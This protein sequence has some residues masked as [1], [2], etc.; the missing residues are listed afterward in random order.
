[1]LL[2]NRVGLF[3]SCRTFWWVVFL[4]KKTRFVEFNKIVFYRRIIS[5]SCGRLC[6]Y[7]YNSPC[8]R[9]FRFILNPMNITAHKAA[10]PANTPRI[11]FAAMA[12]PIEIMDNIAATAKI[13]M[14]A[15]ALFMKNSSL[16]MYVIWIY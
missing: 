4:C 7:G 14:T 8:S 5:N 11:V 6:V 15:F 9:N 1:M 2:K 3:I 13:N 10:I 12:Y 16:N